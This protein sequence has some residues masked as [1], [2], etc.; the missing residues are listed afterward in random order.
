MEPNIRKAA[1][2][3][4]DAFCLLFDELDALH[5][6]NLP[7]IFQKPEGPVREEAYFR[8]LIT[9]ENTGLFVAEIGEDIVGFVYAI[10]KATPDFPI[11][12]PRRFAIIDSI[13]VRS[14]FN[15]QGIGYM[16]MDTV[17]EWAAAN[18]ATAVELNVYEFNE[19]AIAF[20]RKLG[21]ETLTRRMSRPLENS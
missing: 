16:L 13:V 5:R 9:D 10:I 15:N 17:H 1:I 20:Y 7:Q 14:E 4:Y 19:P 21:Y 8:G 12:V 18:G 6:D 11:F 2:T 3:D